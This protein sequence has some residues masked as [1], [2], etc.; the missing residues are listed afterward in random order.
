MFIHTFYTTK[1]KGYMQW[2][3]NLILES[4]KAQ[5]KSNPRLPLPGKW[6]RYTF[7]YSSCLVKP[8]TL[9]IIYTTNIR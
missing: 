4:F 2:V 8:K 7:P 1:Y 6:N 5:I 3:Q 9:P